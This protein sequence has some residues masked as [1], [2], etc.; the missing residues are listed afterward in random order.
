[1]IFLHFRHT[2][3][4]DSH[5]IQS[6]KYFVCSY[7]CHPWEISQPPCD[8]W[9][10]SL[11]EFCRSVTTPETSCVVLFEWLL[12]IRNLQPC[13]HCVLPKLALSSF[14]IQGSALDFSRRYR[15]AEQTGISSV[16]IH[17]AELGA[18]RSSSCWVCLIYP[19]DIEF[20]IHEQNVLAGN[21]E[22]M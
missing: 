14:S 8:I 12:S 9:G 6:A 16:C 17:A 22:F 13:L 18:S 11:G 1:M 20:T 5:L 19:R 2:S 21:A 10:V 7:G 4:T 15:L 3:P